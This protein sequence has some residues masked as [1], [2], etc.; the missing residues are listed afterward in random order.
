VA[1][2]SNQLAQ[3]HEEAYGKGQVREV[4]ALADHVAQVQGH[5]FACEADAETAIAEYEGR[6]RGQRGRRT[7]QWRYH[8]VRYGVEAQWQRKKRSQRGR[9]RKGEAVENERVYRLHITTKALH[10]PL[11]TLG[12]LVLATTVSEQTCDDA[13]IVRAY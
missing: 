13:E 7:C 10:P 4:E 8:E 5:R 11:S 3:H 12:W 2:Y 9:P 1:V 6:G